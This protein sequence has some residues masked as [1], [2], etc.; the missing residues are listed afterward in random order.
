MIFFLIIIVLLYILSFRSFNERVSPF[1]K[2]H[3]SILKG[4]NGN[5]YSRFPFVL[6]N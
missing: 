4:G 1:N 6:S 3:V 2:E 5:V